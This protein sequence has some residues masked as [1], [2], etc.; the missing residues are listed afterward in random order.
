MR[1]YGLAL[2]AGAAVLGACSGGEKKADS[3]AGA[4]PTPTTTTP[5]APA[6]AAGAVAAMP[7]TGATHEV[8][9][10]GDDKGYRFEPAALTIKTGDAVKFIMVTGGPH[11]VAFDPTTTPADSKAQLDANMDQKMSELSSPMLMN[12]NEAYS[13]SFAG[14]KPGVYPFHCTPHLAMNMKGVITVQ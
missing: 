4:T 9:M 7:A 8:K 12:P 6:A 2:L 1:F 11:N 13:I 3:T 14:V 5:A 10:I